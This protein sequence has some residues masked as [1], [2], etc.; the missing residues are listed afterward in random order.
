MTALIV[1]AVSLALIGTLLQ[2]R[3]WYVARRRK[4]AQCAHRWTYYSAWN[5]G[6]YWNR[7]CHDCAKEEPVAMEAVPAELIP[8]ERNR[9][10]RDGTSDQLEENN[11]RHG[12]ERKEQHAARTVMTSPCAQGGADDG[13]RDQ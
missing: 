13:D 9:S 10:S 7:R 6:R 8:R 3:D 2:L 12:V 4:S 1:T 5:E 11:I